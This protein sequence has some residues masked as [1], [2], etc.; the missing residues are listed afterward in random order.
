MV[1]HFYFI[2]F[3]INPRTLNTEGRLCITD[4]VGIVHQTSHP[5]V[6]SNRTVYNLGTA[7]TKSGPA[8]NIV[9]FPNGENMFEDAFV[10]GS[11]PCRWKLYPGYMHTFGTLAKHSFTYFV[12]TSL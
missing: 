1:L 5:H 11:I 9:C 7:T 3:R 4:F 8:Y 10:V 2:L 12:R 6:M